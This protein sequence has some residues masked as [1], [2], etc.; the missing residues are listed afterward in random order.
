MQKRF[1]LSLHHI[2]QLFPLTA[3]KMR[4]KL[5]VS[6][7]IANEKALIKKSPTRHIQNRTVIQG[8]FLSPYHMRKSSF[9]EN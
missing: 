7:V 6:L 2:S 1:N 4:S 9:Q 3:F 8:K 5:K